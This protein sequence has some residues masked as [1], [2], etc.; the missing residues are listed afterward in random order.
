M[1]NESFTLPAWAVYLFLAPIFIFGIWHLNSVFLPPPPPPAMLKGKRVVLLI[2]HPDDESMFFAPT[3]LRLADPT[4]GNHVKVICLSTGNADGL[5]DTR[6]KELEAAAVKLGI[7]SRE[8]VLI[9]ED[10]RFIDGMKE[11]W[12]EKEIAKVLA[13]AFAPD[14]VVPDVNDKKAKKKKMS[15]G[16]GPKATID[17]L[18]TFDEHGVSSHPNHIALLHGARQFLSNLMRDHSGYSCPI[19]LYTLSSINIFRKYS[20]VLDILPTY[21]S[22]IVSDIFAGASGKKKVAKRGISKGSKGD[23]VVFISDVSRYFKARD[24]MVNAHKSQMVWFRWGWIG[25]G[26]YMVVNDLKRIDV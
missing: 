14:A 10:E 12:D 9:M 19:T 20:F 16:E 7:R 23:R 17:A 5:G 8:D 18:I 24:A 2:A 26:R 21:F 1:A 22:G 3:L 4:L 15:S 11:H 25:I 13:Q 6:K